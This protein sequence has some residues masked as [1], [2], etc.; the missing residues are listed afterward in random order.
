MLLL[1]A[2]NK[3]ISSSQH[4]QQRVPPPTGHRINWKHRSCDYSNEFYIKNQRSPDHCESRRVVLPFLGKALLFTTPPT[5][6]TSAPHLLTT[7][8]RFLQTS[9]ALTA[10]DW[11]IVR[12]YPRFL[13]LIGP[14][15]RAFLLAQALPHASGSVGHNTETHRPRRRRPHTTGSSRQD[16]KSWRATACRLKRALGSQGVF[17]PEVLCQRPRGGGVAEAGAQA[18]E[19]APG[20]GVAPAALLG[21]LAQL[22]AQ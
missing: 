13:R 9:P 10:S 20:H 2:V 11:S 18:H 12:I 1:C 5:T 14:H 8:L 22:G 21:P 19:A 3:A 4:Q 16:A 7:T 17:D 15:C 6:P